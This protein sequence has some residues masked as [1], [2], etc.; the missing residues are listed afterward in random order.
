MRNRTITLFSSAILA[1][2]ATPALATNV[3]SLS[4]GGMVSTSGSTIISIGQ[5][6]IGLTAAPGGQPSALLGFIPCALGDSC[7]ADLDNGSGNGTPDGAV[8][9]D[10]LLYFL[11]QFEA[12]S[13]GADLD[14]GSG[15]GTPDGAVTI[16]D[17]LFFLI[18]FED[19]C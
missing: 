9:I 2:T 19:G 11:I 13:A 17:L 3:V 15:T 12:G 16:D 18:H 7:P 14:N 6:M 10:D 1:A 4:S 5:P 8:T